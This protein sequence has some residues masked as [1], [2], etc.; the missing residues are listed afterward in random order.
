[1]T[2]FRG[3]SCGPR[4]NILDVELLNPVLNKSLIILEWE[5]AIK[6]AKEAAKKMAVEKAK[7]AGL[8]RAK[9]ERAGKCAAKR[10]AWKVKVQQVRHPE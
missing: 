4:F 3:P 1:M 5:A 2:L 8:S 6:K 10:A 9:A 7:K